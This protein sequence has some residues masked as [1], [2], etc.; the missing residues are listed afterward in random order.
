[1]TTF[2]HSLSLST[3]M[4]HFEKNIRRKIR[5]TS[6]IKSKKKTRQNPESKRKQKKSEQTN[7]NNKFFF[8]D[9]FHYFHCHISEKKWNSS[10]SWCLFFL[11]GGIGGYLFQIHSFQQQNWKKIHSFR[12]SNYSDSCLFFYLSIYLSRW[13][14]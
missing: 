3:S 5:K 2:S 10:S 1:M 9:R 6:N 14:W 13:L 11:G 4:K 7:S 12:S 8:F